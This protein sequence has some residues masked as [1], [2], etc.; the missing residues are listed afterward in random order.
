[1]PRGR[2]GPASWTAQP[3]TRLRRLRS[4]PTL[5]MLSLASSSLRLVGALRGSVSCSLRAPFFPL[6]ADY[7]PTHTCR[8]LSPSCRAHSIRTGLRT[9]LQ[10][11]SKEMPCS[12]VSSRWPGRL[13]SRCLI[14]TLD[15]S[16][17]APGQCDVWCQVRCLVPSEYTFSDTTFAI[18][19]RYGRGTLPEI[20]KHDAMSVTRRLPTSS[21]S[22]RLIAER[23]PA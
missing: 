22:C 5:R 18:S 20:N 10:I 4:W 2:S 21:H 16:T 8:R 15:N 1:M 13:R 19:L 7:S 12:N 3:S 6:D 17:S 23:A 9:L 11:T 14:N